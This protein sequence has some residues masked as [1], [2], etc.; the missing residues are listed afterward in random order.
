MKKTMA[1]PQETRSRL[2]WHCGDGGSANRLSGGGLIL[3][4]RRRGESWR[5]DGENVGRLKA[6][7]RVGGSSHPRQSS[8]GWG[9]LAGEIGIGRRRSRGLGSAQLVEFGMDH[10][11]G[12][13][14]VGLKFSSGD[15]SPAKRKGFVVSYGGLRHNLGLDFTHFYMR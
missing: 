12:S 5:T 14:W 6:F 8:K 3:R 10:V 1:A 2:V 13:R 4:R 15:R 9:K 11:G 7:F